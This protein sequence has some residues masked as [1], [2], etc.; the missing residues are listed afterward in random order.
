MAGDARVHFSISVLP[1]AGIGAAIDLQVIGTSRW[2][3]SARI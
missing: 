3:L 1:A 2:Q